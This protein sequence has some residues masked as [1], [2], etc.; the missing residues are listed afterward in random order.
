[1]QIFFNIWVF[2]GRLK[3]CFKQL[4]QTAALIGRIYWTFLV[5]FYFTSLLFLYD[6]ICST[7]FF[8]ICSKLAKLIRHL[9]IQVLKIAMYLVKK[10]CQVNLLNIAHVQYNYLL[11]ITSKN[12]S[13]QDNEILGWCPAGSVLPHGEKV[14]L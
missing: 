10:K 9:P 5:F 2:F 13:P 1:M 3:G 11:L 6:P 12:K 8:S 7:F 4:L 14:P